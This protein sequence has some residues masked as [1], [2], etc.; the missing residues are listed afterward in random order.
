MIA[1]GK[2][3]MATTTPRVGSRALVLAST[4][5]RRRARLKEGGFAHQAVSPGIDDG[6]LTVPPKAMARPWV[7]ALAYL[8]AVSALERLTENV[9]GVVILAADTAVVADGEI[10]G[11]A[12]DAEDARRILQR[13]SDRAHEVYTGAA[14]LAA[15]WRRILVDVAQVQVGRLPAD[16]IEGYVASGQWAG[17]AGAYNLVER[18][19]AG[20][21]IQFRGDPGTIMGLPMRMLT[22][23]LRRLLA[24]G[25]P[26]EGRAS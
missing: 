9:S 21:P 16:V 2:V 6:E 14:I 3:G 25:T 18:L 15:G 1:Q 26:A 19:E 5:P 4:S 22:P 10:I 11:Q 8:K 13:L 23:L 12:R 20:W 24:P 17:K 7:G